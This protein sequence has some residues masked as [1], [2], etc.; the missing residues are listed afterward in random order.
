MAAAQKRR[1]MRQSEELLLTGSVATDAHANADT[2][3]PNDTLSARD[4]ENNAALDA[5][6]TV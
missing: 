3:A 1:K 2:V 6:A 5:G 4:A